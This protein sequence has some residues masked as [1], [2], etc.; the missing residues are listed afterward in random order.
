MKHLTTTPITKQFQL[1]GK[2]SLALAMLILTLASCSKND[3]T[4]DN[5]GSIV[6]TWEFAG[7]TDYFQSTGGTKTQIGTTPSDISYTVTFRS[8]G[9]YT[10]NDGSNIDNGNYVIANNQMTINS[11][12]TGETLSDTYNIKTLNNTDL[13]LEDIETNWTDDNGA[14]GTYYYEALF[15]RK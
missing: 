6:G 3:D 1:F 14:V 4:G 11:S 9:T 5:S 15:K 8:N 13:L 7:S 2:L 10:S 12:E